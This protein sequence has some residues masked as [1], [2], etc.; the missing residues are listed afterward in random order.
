MITLLKP[1]KHPKDPQNL[2]PIS[3][4]ST[5]VKLLEKD[6]LKIFQRHVEKRGL[7][8]ASQFGLRARQSTTLQC[9]WL[10]E[11]ITLNLNNNVSKAA[12]FLDSETHLVNHGTLARHINNLS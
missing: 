6:I 4:L 9:A 7:L 10:T 3:L 11:H 1:D 2:R 8:N 12:V 5:T